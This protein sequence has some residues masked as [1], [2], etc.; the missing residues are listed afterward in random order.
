MAIAVAFA[1]ER[2]ETAPHGLV[3]ISVNTA[4]PPKRLTSGSVVNVLQEVDFINNEA[5]TTGG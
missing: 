1:G 4:Y 2:V 5:P 3:P